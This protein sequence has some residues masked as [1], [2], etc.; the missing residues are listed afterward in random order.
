MWNWLEWLRWL[1]VVVPGGYAPN[2]SS[3]HLFNGFWLV[4]FFRLSGD[5]VY[6]SICS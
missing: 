1:G 3:V 2:D 5:N 4:G 6:G